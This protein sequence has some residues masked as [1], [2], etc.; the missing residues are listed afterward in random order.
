M[1]DYYVGSD[2]VK[3][4]TESS[5]GLFNRTQWEY[6][7]TGEVSQIVIDDE[8]GD[9]LV[10]VF[11]YDNARRLVEVRYSG[12]VAN[13]YG[14][15]QTRVFTYDAAGNI[16]NETSSSSGYPV[17]IVIDK[18]FDAYSHIEEITQGG[19]TEFYDYNDNGTL[20][21]KT[22]GNLNAT[23]FTYDAFK[24]LTNTQSIGQVNTG[25]TYDVH[26]N[27]ESVTD[28][29]NNI[30]NYL[31]DDLGNL[32]EQDSPDTGVTTNTF[33][34]SG[35]VLTTTDAKGQVSLYSYD[36]TG[37]LTSLDRVG[38]DD[39]LTYVY[40][41][42][43]NGIGR[44]CSLAT[45]WGH[46]IQYEWNAIGELSTVT[47]NEGQVKYTYGPQNTLTSIEYPS[48]RRIRY[49]NNGKTLPVEIILSMDGLPEKALVDQIVYSANGAPSYWRFANGHE[50]TISLDARNRPFEI[51]T[52]GVWNWQANLYDANDNLLDLNTSFESYSFGYDTQNRLTTADTPLIP[53]GFVYDKVGNRLSKTTDSV[54]ELG[55]YETQ[56]NRM[57]TFG[58][59]QYTLDLNGN[60]ISTAINQVPDKTYMYSSHNRL[61]D[62]I[63]E[64]T[65]SVVATYK[66]DGLGQR[67][68]KSTAT[69]TT[70]FIYGLNG[71]LLAEIDDTGKILH[72]YVY[73][74]GTPVVDLYEIPTAPPPGG[75][76]EVILE[77]GTAETNVL[78]SNWQTKSNSAAENG[79][80]LQNRKIDERGHYWYIDFDPIFQGGLYD[81]YVKW[82]TPS[83][84]GTQTTY[85]I[86]HYI[87]SSGSSETI[88]VDINHAGLSVGD[89]VLLGR[90]SF[91][92]QRNGRFQGIGLYGDFG[93]FTPSNTG[94]HGCC[95]N[96]DAIKY[97]ALP[98][99]F[100]HVDLRFIHN[101]HLGT[102]QVVTDESGQTIWSATYLPFGEATVDEDPDGDSSNY[103]FNIRF[104]GQY[105]DAESGLHYNYYRTYDPS[106][107]RY[108][109]SDPIGLLG[110][111]NT[112]AYV[113]ANPLKFVDPFGEKARMR[114]VDVMFG[115]KHCYVEIEPDGGGARVSWALHGNTRGAKSDTGWIL[116][117]DGFDMGGTEGEWNEDC[118]VEDCILDTIWSYANPSEYRILSGPNS[119]TFAGTIAR[120]CGLEKA[121]GWAPGWSDP[122]AEQK[123]GTEYQTPGKQP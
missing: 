70:E 8:V 52:P 71:E 123:P 42:C 122:P 10:T 12:D 17:S 114:C 1:Y 80:Y 38:T 121:P 84:Q 55:T 79:S 50:T 91:T 102:P 62:L 106:I 112:F 5:G 44:L 90:F 98:D 89:W 16:T 107:G 46:S 53:V 67:V 54:I 47:T 11:Q 117:N 115:G 27:I 92:D 28:A 74:N 21:S 104:P 41:I 9:E 15:G 119:N 2:R 87:D 99:P 14:G 23:T 34:E 13:T 94:L 6:A 95:F 109:E 75:V 86:T 88:K 108:L 30:T 29:E 81:V 97:M 19:I 68:L 45:G 77:S 76:T 72:E 69:D 22:D 96:A 33:S 101:D 61:T 93:G 48:G 100:E 58:D 59:K 7:P 83:G 63:D 40:D 26:S 49:V 111:L 118:F 103:N 20:A 65:S 31:Y 64:T 110:G 25:K 35:Q 66:Y 39:D 4:M 105:Y 85:D 120:E 37:R 43:A 113:H 73:L 24:R 3:S 56:S 78:G 18:L 57:L 51:D 82:L 60:T 36:A 32:I 116:K